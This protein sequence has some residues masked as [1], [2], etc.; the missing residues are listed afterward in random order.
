MLMEA[1]FICEAVPKGN[2]EERRLDSLTILELFGEMEA[3]ANDRNKI[4]RRIEDAREKAT[5]TSPVYSLTKAAG[6]FAGSKV[7]RGALEAVSGGSILAE[8]EA[9]LAQ[10]RRRIEP[11]VEQLDRREQRII[12]HKRFIQGMSC[13]EIAMS[14][15]YTTSGVYKALGKA[16][17]QM[18]SLSSRSVQ[19]R[20]V[21]ST[22]KG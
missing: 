14:E 1:E 19:A 18:V 2:P 3:L 11:Y 15:H 17:K 7:E 6:G 21:E 4:L 8:I 12:A 13:E 20:P 10:L 22:G 9:D 5:G 16:K